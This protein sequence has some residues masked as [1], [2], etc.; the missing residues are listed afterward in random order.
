MKVGIVGAGIMG[1]SAAWAL[2][3]RG[4]H[5]S[6]FEQY[7]IPNPLGSSVDQHRLIRYPYGG[8]TGYCRM[9]DAGFGAWERLWADLG[10]RLYA[11]TGTIGIDGAGAD[12]VQRSAA[13]MRE[14]GIAFETLDG[15]ALARRFPHLR[16][17]GIGTALYEP[18]GGAL[19]AGRI[20]ERLAHHLGTNGVELHAKT[21]VADVDAERARIR[22]ADSAVHGFDRVI[23][24]AGPW[25]TRLVPGLAARVTPS[26]QIVVYLAPPPSQEA[27]WAAAPMMIERQRDYVYYAVPPRAGLG[28]KFG[29]HRFSLAGDPDRE[30][31]A[32][33]G[34]AEDLLAK[35]RPRFRDGGQYRIVEAKTCFYDVEPQERFI[36]EPLGAAGLV[37][38]GFSGHGF[39]FGALMGEL[40]AAAVIGEKKPDSIRRY[41]AGESVEL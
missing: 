31:E 14:V 16:P 26:R 24:A 3:R 25:I 12:W 35:C 29:D 17:E 7:A 27:A 40:A 1:L 5:V 4:A 19:F 28:L 33:R 32:L 11:E 6:V 36:L 10:E 9:I 34:E 22:L 21:K 41:A 18:R 2:M 38:S 8:D 15:N 23:V 37:M 39:K 13:S 30:R 20:V